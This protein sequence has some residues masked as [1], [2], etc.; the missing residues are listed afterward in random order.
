VKQIREI[1]AKPIDRT[2]EE[3]IKVEQADEKA[4]LSELEE[5]IPTD[6]LR[7]Q[8]GHV[9]KE[10]ASGPA[11]PREGVGIWISGFFGSGKSLFAK[12]LGYTVA[13]RKVGSK[14]ASAIFKAKLEDPV[15]SDL[16]DS[17][18][19]RIPFTITSRAGKCLRCGWNSSRT[20][21]GSWWTTL[22]KLYGNYVDTISRKSS[23]NIFPLV[24]T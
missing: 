22:Q 20:A 14:T 9:Y 18:T 11:V 24:S 13:A 7:E 6:Y 15:V 8:F 21:T 19:T 17:I 3:V 12:I 2:I 10:I 23:T 5:Y 16:L 4:V 1:F